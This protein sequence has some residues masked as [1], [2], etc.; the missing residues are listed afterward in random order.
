MSIHDKN[1]TARVARI[2]SNLSKI[3]DLMAQMNAARITPNDTTKEHTMTNDTTKEHTMT[4]E[5]NPLL[6]YSIDELHDQLRDARQSLNSYPAAYSLQ[7]RA[8]GLH[9]QIAQE[10]TTKQLER[11]RVSIRSLPKITKSRYILDIYAKWEAAQSSFEDVIGTEKRIDDL[12]YTIRQKPLMRAK[13][14]LTHSV[15]PTM[16]D[17]LLQRIAK[18]GVTTAQNANAR[19]QRMTKNALRLC[20]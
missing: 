2:R 10:L 17:V 11:F 3:N 5:M 20:R 19:T 13:L 18:H 8:A 12:L 7:L 1:V 15:A 14:T 9:E 6:Q 16:H 4:N